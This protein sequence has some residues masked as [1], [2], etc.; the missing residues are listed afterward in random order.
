MLKGDRLS[1]SFFKLEGVRRDKH[2]GQVNFKMTIPKRRMK[3]PPRA[4]SKAVVRT[5]AC[6]QE[7]KNYKG[8]R[9]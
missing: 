4:N 8:L 7:A 5:P 6:Y 1:F 2:H 3:L 9:S